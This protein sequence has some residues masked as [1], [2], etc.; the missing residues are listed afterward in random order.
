MSTI[1]VTGDYEL[2]IPENMRGMNGL[3]VGASYEVAFHKH[4]IIELIPTG[5]ISE[6]RGIFEGIDTNIDRDETD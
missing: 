4:N 1:T 3:K 6:L 5:P 2:V